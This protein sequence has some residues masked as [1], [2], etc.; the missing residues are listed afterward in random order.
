V[1]LA[2]KVPFIVVKEFK[3]DRHKGV[4]VKDLPPET[5]VRLRASLKAAPR[6]YVFVGADGQPYS[7]PDTFKQ[8]HL[9]K[10]K[11]W[12]ENEKVT[13]NSLR[14]A[15]MTWVNSMPLTMKERRQ[16]AYDMGHSVEMGIM[17]AFK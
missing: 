6:E 7:S 11:K 1:D 2:V 12:F 3:T 13:N 17:Y 8:H 15:F 9:R 5:L 16:I 10:L 4:W 14:H